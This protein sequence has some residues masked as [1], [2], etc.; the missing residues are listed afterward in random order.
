MP[1]LSATDVQRL[2]DAAV[3]TGVALDRAPLIGGLPRAYAAHLPFGTNPRSQVVS[4]LHKM[5]Q[6]M[7]LESG[8][9]PLL[10]WLESALGESRELPGH[11]VFREVYDRLVAAADRAPAA[12]T[13]PESGEVIIGGDDRL[14]LSFFRRAAETAASV[15]HLRVPLHVDG[16]R[17][18]DRHGQPA[19][20][21]GTGWMFGEGLL[22]T[23]LHV[24][25][26]RPPFSGDVS[27]RDLE[28]QVGGLCTTWDY[29]EEGV[30]GPP[31]S[32]PT[33]QGA[34]L[35]VQDAALDYA[36]L[37][38]PAGAPSRPALRLRRQPLAVA[39]GMV[40]P[41]VNIVQHGG[42]K[43]KS[44]GFR[45]NLATSS[46]ATTLRYFTDT[47]PGSS[48]SPV[49][50]DQWCVVALHRAGGDTDPVH[51]FQGR[52]HAVVNVGTPI[53]AILEDLRRRDLWEQLGSRLRLVE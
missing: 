48:G 45:N 52:E 13:L 43:A 40:R 16:V 15:V 14:P 6:D 30:S 27:D 46:D 25:R 26:A 22:I 21:A 7:R 51:N 20:G 44:V 19:W 41:A 37:D 32:C 5:N 38:L 53:A 17:V 33:V 39:R 29:D 1:L 2:A 23:N 36:L 34:T 28:L 11:E 35:L 47:E 49:C 42:G 4:D 18:V 12:R 10:V 3:R 8:V 9:V 31:A 50:D 24:L